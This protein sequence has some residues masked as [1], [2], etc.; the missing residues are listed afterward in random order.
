MPTNIS[1]YQIFLSL[2]ALLF[3][4]NSAVR[5][6][7]KE[8][9][10]SFFKFSTTLVIWG[11]ILFVGL[12]PQLAH[13]ISQK[14]GMGESLNTLIFTG[15]VVI[16]MVI[17]KLLNIIEKLERNISELVRKEALNKLDKQIEEDK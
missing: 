16:F 5:F 6:L 4:V 15:F 12:Y 11:F 9:S 17:Y 1:V 10:Q 14:F 3:L 2:I 13:S 8:K 7:K